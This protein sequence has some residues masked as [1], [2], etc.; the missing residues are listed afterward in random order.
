MLVSRSFLN[1]LS[2]VINV[3]PAECLAPI[4]SGLAS[5]FFSFNTGVLNLSI[6]AKE[7]EKSVDSY[8]RYKKK[9]RQQRTASR[10]FGANMFGIGVE[11]FLIQHW[12]IKLVH[13]FQ[14]NNKITTNTY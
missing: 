12:C 3:P 6:P 1:R 5:N 4:C 14:A 11:L 8:N 2:L 9:I 13:P 10:V 7:R